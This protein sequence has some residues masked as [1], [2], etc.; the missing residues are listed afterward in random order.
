[1]KRGGPLKRTGFIRRR[2]PL[3]Q[4]SAKRKREAADRRAV[5]AEVIARDGNR[6]SIAHLVPEVA[7]AGPLDPDEEVM[8]GQR[9]DAHLDA[10]NVR[11]ICRAHHDWSHRERLE[12]ARRGIRPWP[13]G[14]L[15]PTE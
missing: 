9:K 15:G 3:R 14:Y 11:M 12:A 13:K 5:V 4:Q 2:T 6:C 1:V 7:C 8:R 10:S